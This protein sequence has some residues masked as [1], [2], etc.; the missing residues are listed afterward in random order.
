MVHHR[1]LYSGLDYGPGPRN[2]MLTSN[3]DTGDSPAMLRNTAFRAVVQSYPT[4]SMLPLIYFPAIFLFIQLVCAKN[5]ETGG[6][7][8]SCC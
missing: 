1:D 8:A 2:L 5:C 3:V 6:V 4:T 7:Q